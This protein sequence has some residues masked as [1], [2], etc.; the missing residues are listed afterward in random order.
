MLK[1]IALALIL[2]LPTVVYAQDAARRE[3][4]TLPVNQIDNARFE[5]IEADG[6]GGTQMWCAAGIFARDVL[7]RRDGNLYIETGRGDAI[8]VPG[9]K[10]V[11]FSTE[12]VDGAFSSVSQGIRRAG[13]VFSMAHAYS[14]CRNLPF[15]KIRIS[16]DRLVRR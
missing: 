4:F 15:L 7:M 13:K 14:L 3:R 2:T 16:E 10:G 6:A 12:P 8:T 9:R 1:P 11:T 5:V